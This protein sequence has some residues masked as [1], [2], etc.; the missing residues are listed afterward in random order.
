MALATASVGTIAVRI[1]RAKAH[2]P[3]RTGASWNCLRLKVPTINS[4]NNPRRFK[5]D[6]FT[7]TGNILFTA[8]G[9]VSTLFNAMVAYSVFVNGFKLRGPKA[10][11][12]LISLENRGEKNLATIEYCVKPGNVQCLLEAVKCEEH[13]VFP[14]RTIPSS[15]FEPDFLIQ[16][17]FS[18]LVPRE[19]QKVELKLKFSIWFHNI[20]LP[21]DLSHEQSQE[22]NKSP[23]RSNTESQGS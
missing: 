2:K 15:D 23:D 10:G 3:E 8:I 21:M 16:D 6:F 19:T 5:L 14:N 20:R 1:Q 4:L 22:I 9:A 17:R 11:A 18:I 7:T 13:K 12:K